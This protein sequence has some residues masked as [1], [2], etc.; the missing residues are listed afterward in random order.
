M[1]Y[2]ILEALNMFSVDIKTDDFKV[3]ISKLKKAFRKKIM[4]ADPDKGG[5]KE[6]AQKILEANSLIAK[7]ISTGQLQRYW[8]SSNNVKDN[9]DDW[10]STVNRDAPNGFSS[11]W[12][13]INKDINSLMGQVSKHLGSIKPLLKELEEG[14][15]TL[16]H[17]GYKFDVTCQE[18]DHNRKGIW[19]IHS[20]SITKV[21]GVEDNTEENKVLLLLN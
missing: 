21:F 9:Y 19:V 5:T 15:H 11:T 14:K 8:H 2:K 12:D 1:D 10:K 3:Y 18:K 20:D 16:F 6:D 7:A 13:D 17:K 4:K